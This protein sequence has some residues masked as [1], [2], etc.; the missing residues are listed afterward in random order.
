MSDFCVFMDLIACVPVDPDGKSPSGLTVALVVEE[1]DP[2]LAEPWRVDNTLPLFVKGTTEVSVPVG[3]RE[4]RRQASDPFIGHDPLRRWPSQMWFT[5]RAS[6]SPPLHQHAS[7]PCLGLR[8]RLYG[9][10]SGFGCSCGC[11][12][13]CGCEQCEVSV[14]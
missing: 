5:V 12:F 9:G 7:T 11:G 6:Q 4:G 2:L 10:G 13:G 3:F 1:G 14:D 8:H